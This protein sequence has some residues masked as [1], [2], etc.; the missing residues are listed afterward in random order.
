MRRELF[1]F[2]DFMFMVYLELLIPVCE[3]DVELVLYIWPILKY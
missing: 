2:D 3:G 1:V